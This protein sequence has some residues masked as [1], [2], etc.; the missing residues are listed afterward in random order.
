MSNAACA[1]SKPCVPQVRQAICWRA[2]RR[3]SKLV[4]PKPRNSLDA[5]KR[6]DCMSEPLESQHQPPRFDVAVVLF[7]HVVHL[8]VRTYPE[9]LKKWVLYGQCAAGFL[10]GPLSSQ[11]DRLRHC[12]RAGSST[13]FL[14]NGGGPGFDRSAAALAQLWRDLGGRWPATGPQQHAV[15]HRYQYG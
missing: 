10:R 7:T 9:L 5:G 6:D 8:S 2:D 1:D 14:T 11:G 15:V 13:V 3:E 12:P 4:C